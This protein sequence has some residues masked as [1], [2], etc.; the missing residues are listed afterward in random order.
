L[1]NELILLINLKGTIMNK[2]KRMPRLL[3]DFFIKSITRKVASKTMNKIKCVKNGGTYISDYMDLKLAL[4]DINM[5]HNGLVGTVNSL[6]RNISF[7]LNG[8]TI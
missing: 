8:Y 5:A 6:S 2:Q 3:K 7:N 4:I 1:A